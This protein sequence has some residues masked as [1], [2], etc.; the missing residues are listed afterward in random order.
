MANTESAKVTRENRFEAP[1]KRHHLQALLYRSL[2][3]L[4]LSSPLHA[5]NIRDYYKPIGDVFTYEEWKRA[6]QFADETDDVV[7][8]SNGP[9]IHGKFETLP[10]LSFS[11]GDLQLDP[12]S[13][14]LIAFLDEGQQVRAQYI[15]RQGESYVGRL[16]DNTVVF[17]EKSSTG[18][19]IGRVI[20]PRT[21]DAIVLAPRNDTPVVE[22][23]KL[24]SVELKN[25]D[26]LPIAPAVDVINLTD[27]RKDT[28]LPVSD[29]VEVTYNGGLQGLVNDGNG[30]T[31]DLG[32]SLVK[33]KY[34]CFHLASKEQTLKMPW[35]NVAAI[36]GNNSGFK[37]NVSALEQKLMDQKELVAFEPEAFEAFMMPLPLKKPLTLAQPGASVAYDADHVGKKPSHKIGV[38]PSNTKPLFACVD[39]DSPFH[40]AFHLDY[41]ESDLDATL[42]SSQHNYVASNESMAE[43]NEPFDDIAFDSHSMD[44]EGILAYED[45]STFSPRQAG[46]R[47]KRIPVKMTS[48]EITSISEDVLFENLPTKEIDPPTFDV[49][50]DASDTTTKQS[51]KSPVLVP[52]ATKTVEKDRDDSHKLPANSNNVKVTIVPTSPAPSLWME[53]DSYYIDRRPVSNAEYQVFV[54]EKKRQ[55]P[56]HWSDGKVPEGMEDKPVVNVSYDDAAAYAQWCGK[57]L[58]TELEWEFATQ[59]HLFTTSP[60]LNEWVATSFVS[61]SSKTTPKAQTPYRAEGDRSHMVASQHANDLILQQEKNSNDHTTFRCVH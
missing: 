27:G 15:S 56:S 51:R 36:Q 55:H 6:Q 4:A 29:I 31:K 18:G 2:M 45:P 35:E 7:L 59:E 3:I 28:A 16:K 20:D 39:F 52:P 60:A 37:Q 42:I 57:R 40:I 46:V 34:F 8:I 25:G 5:A 47:S 9:A 10:F 58:P 22:N 53:F 11:F 26:I 24:Y 17:Q 44:D 48:S 21:I 1:K 49:S 19:Y 32:F 30:G 38:A 33:D 50:D 23:Q 13:L 54:A 41:M 61:D 12:S 43:S 14:A